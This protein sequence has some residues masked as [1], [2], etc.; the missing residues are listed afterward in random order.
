MRSDCIA[1]L[2]YSSGSLEAVKIVLQS[3][4]VRTFACHAKPLTFDRRKCLHVPDGV[5]LRLVVVFACEGI[6]CETTC[7]VNFAYN[8]TRWGIRKVSLFAKSHYMYYSRM[9][10]CSG[11]GNSVVIRELSLD[12]KSLLAKLT[13][14]DYC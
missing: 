8:D 2:D 3:I 14:L 7:T 12:P 4:H 9:G 6:D 11:H 5:D 13:V 10:L 1:V